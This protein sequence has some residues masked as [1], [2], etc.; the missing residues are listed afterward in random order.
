L[1]KV[2]STVIYLYE[3]LNALVTDAFAYTAS[4]GLRLNDQERG[5][6]LFIDGGGHRTPFNRSMLSNRLT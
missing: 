1:K 4:P 3:L 6:L 5:V 2:R